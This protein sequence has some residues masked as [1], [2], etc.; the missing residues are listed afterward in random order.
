[1]ILYRYENAGAE[2]KN[3]KQKY[4]TKRSPGNV[5]YVVD[6][7]WE[8]KR[9]EGYP[10][11]RHSVCA[12]PSPELAKESAPDKEQLF[13]VEPKGHVLLV[14]IEV[15]DAKFHD[16][17]K[18]LKKNLLEL[19]GKGW[20]GKSIVEK[21]PIAALWAP[22]LSE[23]DVKELFSKEPLAAIRNKIWNSITFW[24][25][26]RVFNPGDPFP[27]EKGEIFFEADEWCLYPVE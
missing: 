20:V 9:P 17:C 2:K 27:F 3:P 12:S 15:K 24:D 23:K 22:C 19:L 13:R 11:R 10:N 16:D 1:M 21:N 25:N 4:K 14:Q 7:L 8:W 18:N 26:A 6:N 5:P